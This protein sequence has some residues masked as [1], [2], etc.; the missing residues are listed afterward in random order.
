MEKLMKLNLI[1]L[2]IIT[3]FACRS[4]GDLARNRVNRL[5]SDLKIPESAQVNEGE[6]NF[7][8]GKYYVLFDRYSNLAIHAGVLAQC[9]Q[10]LVCAIRWT[11]WERDCKDETNTIWYNISGFRPTCSIES[12]DC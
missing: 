7:S 6:Y 10:T 5:C 4:Q 12:P 11:E 3:T 1:L 9:G 2:M 8:K